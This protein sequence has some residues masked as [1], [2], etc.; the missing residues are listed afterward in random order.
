MRRLP[1]R[2]SC[3]Y[4]A[5]WCG[6]TFG[7]ASFY[8]LLLLVG[9]SF[10]ETPCLDAVQGT[11]DKDAKEE[12]VGGDNHG[13]NGGDSK[14]RNAPVCAEHGNNGHMDCDDPSSPRGM[15]ARMW[16]EALAGCLKGQV[17]EVGPAGATLGRASDNNLCLADKEMSRRHSKVSQGE[18]RSLGDRE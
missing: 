8:R 10:N 12:A 16:L 1:C 9:T 2:F 5:S 17:W 7:H 3:E 15:K 13:D 11:G 4:A 6:K 18:W 14:Q